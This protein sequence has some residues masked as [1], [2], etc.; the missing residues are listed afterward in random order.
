MNVLT[1]VVIALFIIGGVLAIGGYL[2]GRAI[3]I[4]FGATV[5]IWLLG[6][7]AFFVLIAIECAAFKR[8]I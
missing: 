8:C 7:L 3:I 2:Q 4:W 5:L 6:Y 1:L